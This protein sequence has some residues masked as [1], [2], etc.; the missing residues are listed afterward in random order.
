MITLNSEFW[1]NRYLDKETGWDIG[2]VST[3]IKEYF[4][5]VK[6]KE[7]K[8]LIP[9]GG[10]SYEAEFLYNKG[11]SNTFLLDYAKTPLVNFKKRNPKF[12][13]N[14]LIH[15]NFFDYTNN[16]D[17]IIEQTFF[18][19]I[20]PDLRKKYS[21]KCSELLNKNGKIIG[22][23]FDDQLNNDKPPFGGS[24]KEYEIIFKNLFKI[25]K[26]ETSKNSIPQRLGRE[27]FIN[28]EKN[29]YEKK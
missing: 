27:L 26:M 5:Q 13:S 3:P 29:N 17:I 9:G 8:I 7:L 18:C 15:C 23:L 10:N 24:K 2:Y 14:Q 16:F 1:N 28:L 25:K 11:F 6:N 20:Y 19:A 22:L 12:P 21:E 4:N